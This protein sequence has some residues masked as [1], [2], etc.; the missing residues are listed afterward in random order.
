[1]RDTINRRTL[2]GFNKRRSLLE[3]EHQAHS[4]AQRE[5]SRSQIL[6]PLLT[7]IDDVFTATRLHTVAQG[8]PRVPRGTYPG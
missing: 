4:S 5:L 6:L 1:M 3:A 2:K 7:L 8:S